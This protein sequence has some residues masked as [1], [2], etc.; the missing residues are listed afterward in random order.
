MS[1]RPRHDA[2]IRLEK[3]ESDVENTHSPRHPVISQFPISQEEGGAGA[4]NGKWEIIHRGLQPTVNSVH[5]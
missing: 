3:N 5:E 2:K 4:G 1:S